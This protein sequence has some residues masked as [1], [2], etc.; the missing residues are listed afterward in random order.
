MTKKFCSL[1]G[2][3]MIAM[4]TALVGMALAQSSREVDLTRA[5][6][7]SPD[8]STMFAQ[9]TGTSSKKGSKARAWVPEAI[10]VDLPRGQTIRYL[11]LGPS[12]PAASVILFIGGKGRLLR[13]DGTLRVDAEPNFV[14]TIV[15]PLHPTASTPSITAW[16]PPSPHG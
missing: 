6:G 16:S 8:R 2:A 15:I 10:T 3:S 9:R 1:L 14:S 7:D 13:A 5:S 12:A 4:A 11:A